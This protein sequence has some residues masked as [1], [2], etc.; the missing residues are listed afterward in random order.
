M[1]LNIGPSV[2]PGLIWAM[3]PFPG[4]GKIK[5]ARGGFVSLAVVNGESAVT[6][7]FADGITYS[8]RGKLKNL[9]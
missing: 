5:R 9:S 3:I 2:F 1:V 7:S 4:T 6:V 8:F